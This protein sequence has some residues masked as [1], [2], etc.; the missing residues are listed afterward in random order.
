VKVWAEWVAAEWVVVGCRAVARRA[1]PAAVLNR[2]PV[3]VGE[4]AA[5]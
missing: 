5:E 1:E 4:W 2:T 3:R